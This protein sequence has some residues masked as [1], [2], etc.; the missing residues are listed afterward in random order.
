MINVFIIS[1]ADN[2]LRIAIIDKDKC[3]PK[4]CNKEC[5]KCPVNQSGKRC[6]EIEE[7]AKINELLC[8]F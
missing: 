5:K 8:I 2:K 1:M 3:R 6:V 4:K 7:I